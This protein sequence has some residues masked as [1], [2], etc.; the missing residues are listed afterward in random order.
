MTSTSPSLNS[1]SF[2]KKKKHLP[3]KFEECDYKHNEA[4]KAMMT[5]NVPDNLCSHI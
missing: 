4:V 1:F 3:W 2:Y 5:F